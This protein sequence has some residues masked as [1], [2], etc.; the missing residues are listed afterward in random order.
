M[1]NELNRGLYATA[2]KEVLEARPGA[3]RFAKEIGELCNKKWKNGAQMAG[4]MAAI[5]LQN[6][7]TS[8][9]VTLHEPGSPEGEKMISDFYDGCKKDATIRWHEPDLKHWRKLKKL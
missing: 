9:I 1:E 6:I 3:I 7:F 2:P 8:I 5:T 4:V